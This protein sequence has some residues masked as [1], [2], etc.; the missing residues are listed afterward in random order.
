MKWEATIG[1]TVE[2]VSSLYPIGGLIVLLAL[3]WLLD[4]LIPRR[5]R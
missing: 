3:V 1:G 2:D 4:R 5:P